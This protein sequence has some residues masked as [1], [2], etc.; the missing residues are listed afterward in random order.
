MWFF[1]YEAAEKFKV[2]EVWESF[3]NPGC[4]RWPVIE[5]SFEG[6]QKNDYI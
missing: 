1:S 4:E 6:Q 2:T 5:R 3:F